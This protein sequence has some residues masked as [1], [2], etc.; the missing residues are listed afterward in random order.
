MVG[1]LIRLALCIGVFAVAFAASAYV[2]VVV[3]VGSRVFIKVAMNWSKRERV[4]RVVVWKSSKR[5]S[6]VAVDVILVVC[7]M[8]GI[9]EV[10]PGRCLDVYDLPKYVF[11]AVEYR[12]VP[13]IDELF[14]GGIFVLWMDQFRV[15]MFE[16]F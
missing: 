4:A 14:H 11:G 9:V 8:G 3:E 16:V 10:V 15:V 5:S 13:Q 1:R 12:R 7:D 2:G 6:S